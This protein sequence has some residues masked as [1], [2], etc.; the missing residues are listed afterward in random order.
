MSAHHQTAVDMQGLSRDE[1][2]IVSREH[3]H[4]PAMS[5]AVASL[6]SGVEAMM[7]SRMSSVV[8]RLESVPT[9]S[10][11]AMAFT[12]T[13]QAPASCAKDRVKPTNAPLAA[14]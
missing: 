1:R 12:V 5:S 11:A 8:A 9:V 3:G 2:G 4:A 14:V 7:R 6:P 13:P 10:P